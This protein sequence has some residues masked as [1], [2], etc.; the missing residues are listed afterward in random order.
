MTQAGAIR[1][2]DPD[3]AERIAS[4][5]VASWQATYR[6]SMP[7]SDL[8]ALTVEQRLP[9]WE[10]IL[11]SA[12][13]LI[14]VWVAIIDDEIVGFC[15]IGPSHSF[16]DN[17]DTLELYTIYLRPDRERQ[18]TGSALMEHAEREM[19]RMGAGQ[20][21]L[22][23]LEGNHRA[24]HFYEASGWRLDGVEKLDQ[25]FGQTVREVRYSKQLAVNTSS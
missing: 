2:A 9:M 14:R 12:S 17:G 1:N 7:D 20:A 15:S 16:E 4:I 13:A 19:V 21:I 24:R 25:I 8:D 10:R 11:A 18:G 22:W 3:D 5:H 23:V 6:G